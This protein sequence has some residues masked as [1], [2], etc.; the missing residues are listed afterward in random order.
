MSK[1]K[2][3]IKTQD[4]D[5]DI[6]EKS[7]A[8]A[9]TQGITSKAKGKS[10]KKGKGKA[11]FSDSDEGGK[12]DLKNHLSDDEMVPQPAAKKSQK[13]GMPRK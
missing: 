2:G 3:G 8:I 4:L 5:N 11:D 12:G 10:K 1:K 6:E 9:N 7:G 13:K